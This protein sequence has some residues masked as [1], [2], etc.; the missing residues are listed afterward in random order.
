MHCL[1]LR[2]S[3]LDIVLKNVLKVPYEYNKQIWSVKKMATIPLCT[4]ESNISEIN[5]QN[6]EQLASNGH[7]VTNRNTINKFDPVQQWSQYD[8]QNYYK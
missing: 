5:G 1:L 7:N 6:W 8:Q 4:Y 2:L 3:E